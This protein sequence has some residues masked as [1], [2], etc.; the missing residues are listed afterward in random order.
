MSSHD[1]ISLLWTQTWQVTIVALGVWIVLC[2][3]R[4]IHPR[5]AHVLW[6]LVLLKCI[7]PPVWSSPMGAFSFATSQWASQNREP[8]KP[9]IEK[10]SNG[11]SEGYWLK[12]IEVRI[13]SRTNPVSS[14]LQSNSLAKE[15]IT[16]FVTTKSN[17]TLQ[18]FLLTAW[19]A[20]SAVSLLIALIRLHLFG[21]W[22]KRKRQCDLIPFDQKG[23][24]EICLQQMLRRLEKK[25][26]VR[27]RV[28]LSIVHASVGPAVFGLLRPTI[29]LP[30]LLVHGKRTDQI[31]PLIAHELIHVRRGDLWWALVQTLATSLFWFHPLIWFAARML[32]LE[33]ERSCDEE[34][35]A[36]LGCSP[37]NYA[38]SLLDV[39]E[40]KHQ[41]RVAP[42]LPGVR[43]V[44]ITR[45]RLERIMQLGQGCR[46]HGS[47][48][49]IAVLVIGV[50]TILPG[51]GPMMAQDKS[52]NSKVEVKVKGKIYP[53][54]IPIIPKTN[55]QQPGTLKPNSQLKH[56]LKRIDV[57]DLIA[58]I[59]PMKIEGSAGDFLIGHLH[60]VRLL[61]EPTKRTDYFFEF[62]GPEHGHIRVGGENLPIRVFKNDLFVAGSQ[63]DIKQVESALEYL[64]KYGFDQVCISIKYLSI[65]AEQ[66]NK[67]PFQ[68]T[69]AD[70]LSKETLASL[71][72]N[73]PNSNFANAGPIP[74][75][76]K[77]SP[78]SN[79]T[80][81]W[82]P[83][84]TRSESNT[85]TASKSTEP[86]GVDFDPNLTTS[87]ASADIQPNLS[88][89][90]PAKFIKGP[91]N[92]K[93]EELQMMTVPEVAIPTFYAILDAQQVAEMT[94]NVQGDRRSNIMQAPRITMFNGQSAFISDTTITPFVV[95]AK[96]IK[97]ADGTV[98]GYQPVI[99][100]AESGSRIQV[101]PVINQDGSV[102]L[103][104]LL[105]IKGIG[106]VGEFTVG[107]KDPNGLPRQTSGLTIQSPDLSNKA[108]GLKT[109]L[110]KDS[111]AVI[112]GAFSS[113]TGEVENV[114]VVMVSCEVLDLATTHVATQ[115]QGNVPVDKADS[116]LS[117]VFSDE[118]LTKV[119]AYFAKIGY[120]DYEVLEGNVPHTSI[121]HT[122]NDEIGEQALQGMV[123]ML[124]KASTVKESEEKMIISSARK[125]NQA[126]HADLQKALKQMGIFAEVQGD[127]QYSANAAGFSFRA[128]QLTVSAR[129]EDTD[130]EVPFSIYGD[131]AIF[132]SG[133]MMDKESLTAKFE[134]NV[135]IQIN[136]VA[137]TADRLQ[138]RQ[139]SF[140]LE[141]H[142]NLTVDTGDDNKALL[143][144][145][146]IRVSN[147][148]SFELI[149]QGHFSHPTKD[150]K[151]MELSGNRFRWNSETNE[152]QTIP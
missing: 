56:T 140:V 17:W 50:I 9:I 16:T 66:L 109:K 67:L 128:P 48:V 21:R 117:L 63:E 73:E 125:S 80:V 23:R 82:S 39:L 47:W 27:R 137:G 100:L 51:T 118:D 1:A 93:S 54:P 30:A 150:E 143:T 59:A 130:L 90:K 68:W 72:E 87:F 122:S 7:T 3:F 149:G 111:A 31:E 29:I 18:R 147:E 65:P 45:N 146:C 134:G 103:E 107:E 142:V 78:D 135:K 13:E 40:Q 28:E 114:L 8:V 38:R 64:R 99:G 85:T 92:L 61:S 36:R 148:T 12:A 32:T 41:L 141:G 129:L 74:P 46:S 84:T 14:T 19:L 104:M 136:K 88:N 4:K 75:Y 110:P 121:V 113:K 77:S 71:A 94:E 126:N 127:V 133:N 97:N 26:E 35:I 115:T 132:E 102:E 69:P 105:N 49:T 70:P 144:A 34:T 83:N 42:A 55:L 124:N 123:E 139:D 5:V 25:L 152:L 10:S 108:L 89:A 58:K 91:T 24:A 76:L 138:I 96:A 86:I 106:E 44:D 120:T 119:K 43:P 2:S 62:F 112:S 52:K 151:S 131:E 20:G 53:N 22:V 15:D 33:S 37:A 95:Q 11:K 81:A 60:G 6:A 79:A 98:A 57:T 101:R 116:Q 145:D